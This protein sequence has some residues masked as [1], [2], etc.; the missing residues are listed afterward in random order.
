[1]TATRTVIRGARVLTMDGRPDDGAPAD[2]AIEHGRIAEVSARPLPTEGV[3]VI[4]GAGRILL[5]GFVDAHRH[6]WQTAL[7]GVAGDWTLFEYMARIRSV[8]SPRYTADDVHAGSYAGYLEALDAG[9]T[10]VV[11]HSHAMRAPAHADAVLDAMESARIRGV[12][13]YGL[14]AVP[15]EGENPVRAQVESTWR[16]DDV[17]RLRRSRLAADD[18]RVQLG[19]GASDITE[20][21]PLDLVRRELD[22]GRELGLHRITAHVAVGPAT[23]RARLVRRLHRAGLL[24]SDL[25]FAHGNG[26]TDDELRRVADSGGSVVSTPDSELQRGMGLP[27]LA[28]ARARGIAAGLGAD[29]V[30]GNGGDLF[31]AMRLALQVTRFAANERLARSGRAPAHLDVRA[32]D[33]LQAATVDGARAAGLGEVTG[34]ITPGKA[35]DLVLL[36]ADRPATAPVTDPVTTV[37]LQA[38]PADVDTVLVGGD[39][40]K[41]DGRLTGVAVDKAVAALEDSRDRLLAGVD[42]ELFAAAERAHAA[43]LPLTRSGAVL[44]KVA[45]MMLRSDSGAHRLLR[46]MLAAAERG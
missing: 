21:L 2:V 1:M 45:G 22:L 12:L 9:I 36:R 13:A 5:P 10:T 25:L 27:V 23:Q 17:R 34:S 3:A 28:R 11:D 18:A 8:Y 38:S 42:P 26:W 41:R 4:E 43:T 16:Y 20:F 24:G 14:S 46:T 6:V 44:S 31:A 35:A 37:V 30:P 33:V 40:V 32:L 7:R 15:E 29:V 39:V 19:I